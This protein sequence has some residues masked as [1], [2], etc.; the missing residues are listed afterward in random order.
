[1]GSHQILYTRIVDL[2]KVKRSKYR[3]LNS[4]RVLNSDDINVRP[5]LFKTINYF[6]EESPSSI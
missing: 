4:T 2:I 1:M 5:E 6:S 3:N